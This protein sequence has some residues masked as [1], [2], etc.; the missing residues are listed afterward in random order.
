MAKSKDGEELCVLCGYPI[1]GY[2]HNAEPIDKGLCCDACNKT[3]VLSFR[4][5]EAKNAVKG[6]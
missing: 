3:I 1:D 6:A 2:G 5:Q 4:V